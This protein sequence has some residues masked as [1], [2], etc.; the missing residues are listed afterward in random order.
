[1]KVR[2]GQAHSKQVFGEKRPLLRLIWRCLTS[3][4]LTLKRGYHINSWPWR[5]ERKIA[6]G[7]P[8]CHDKFCIYEHILASNRSRPYLPSYTFIWRVLRSCH[9]LISS[10]NVAWHAEPDPCL[11]EIVLLE[12]ECS[13]GQYALVSQT[14]ERHERSKASFPVLLLSPC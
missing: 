14:P 4:W 3:F 5:F 1:M 6:R 8:T 9:N 10:Q 11:V 12:T 2:D 7:T 13:R